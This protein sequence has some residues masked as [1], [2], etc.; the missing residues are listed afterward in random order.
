MIPLGNLDESG[1]MSAS[2]LLLLQTSGNFE[3]LKF[4]INK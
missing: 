3:N 2:R 1:S 4:E